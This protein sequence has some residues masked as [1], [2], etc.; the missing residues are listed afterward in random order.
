[1]LRLPHIDTGTA[2]SGAGHLGLLAW[3]ALG[4]LFYSAPEL[5]LPSATDVTLLSEAEFAA[6]TRAPEVPEIVELPQ[7]PAPETPPAPASVQPAPAPVVSAPPPEPEPVP[8]PAPPPAPAAPAPPPPAPRVAPEPVPTPAPEAEIAPERSEPVTSEAEGETTAEAERET[9]PEAATTRIITEAT[10]TDPDSQA[11]DPTPELTAS[12]RPPLRPARPR[13]TP[14]VAETPPEPASDPVADAVAAA[15]AEAT[16]SAPDPAPSTPARPEI[17]VG[18]PMTSGEREGLRV[19]VQQC[20][21]VGSL[22]SEALRTTVVVGVEMEQSGRP[23][24]GSIR[25]LSSEGGS[26]AAARQAFEAARRAII[27]CGSAGFDLPVEKYGQWRDIEMTFN[28]E[29]MRIR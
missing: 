24:A 17:P 1:M 2:I 21:N 9:A 29:R 4:G 15:V 11:A 6:L 12:P 16:E 13:P 3:L 5:P 25:M 27:R 23:I 10:E 18:P 26:E 14:P 8:V 20:W 7:P 28:P 19:A 22:S